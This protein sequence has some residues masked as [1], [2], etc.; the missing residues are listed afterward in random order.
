MEHEQKERKGGESGVVRFY[1]LAGG[2]RLIATVQHEEETHVFLT[3]VVEARCDAMF[4]QDPVGQ[5][6]PGLVTQ[7]A[8]LP[9]KEPFLLW[10]EV[11]AGEQEPHERMVEA[12]QAFMAN[13]RS[14]LVIAGPDPTEQKKEKPPRSN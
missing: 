5:T 7:F 13:L 11:V 9:V 4:F 12:Y 2:T 3:G 1:L 6:K 10:R 14:G 8:P